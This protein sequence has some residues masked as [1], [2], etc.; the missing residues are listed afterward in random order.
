MNRLRDI[1]P[2]TW[3]AEQAGT[4]ERRQT[5][6][7]E[8]CLS[9]PA[10]GVARVHFVGK[11]EFCFSAPDF[12]GVSIVSDHALLADYS[13]PWMTLCVRSKSLH[14]DK[15]LEVLR[16]ATAQWSG[17]W[18]SF[19]RYANVQYGPERLLRE[20]AGVLLSGPDTLVRSAERVLVADGLTSNVLPAGG[21][22]RDVK[23]L[24]LGSSFVV[25]EHFD[26]ETLEVGFGVG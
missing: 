19:E 5:T 3:P 26:W 22:P 23:A 4:I 25:S 10:R 18:R 16:Q 6:Y 1:V 9:S 13:Q 17:G 2:P 11:L 14:P 12:V 24:I 7:W 8:L 15:T 20:G 21:Q